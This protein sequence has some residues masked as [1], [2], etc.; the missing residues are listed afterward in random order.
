MRE[1][2]RPAPTVA[3][4]EPVIEALPPGIRSRIDG[5][6][7]T[8]SSSTTASWRPTFA[9][10]TRANSAC[11][12]PDMRIETPQAPGVV[13]SSWLLIWAVEIDPPVISGAR[14]TT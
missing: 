3:S 2:R 9:A 1:A 12:L 7:R 8:A 10:V 6:E 5:A 13:W 11:P 14:L 4:N